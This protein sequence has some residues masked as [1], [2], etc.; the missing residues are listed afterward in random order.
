[1]LGRLA[2]S[3]TVFFLVQRCFGTALLRYSVASSSSCTY[4]CNRFDTAIQC[5]FR[6]SFQCS[7]SVLLSVL[8]DGTTL[9]FSSMGR[10]DTAFRCFSSM[11]CFDTAFRCSLSRQSLLVHLQQY[12]APGD[13]FL[14]NNSFA[15][16]SSGILALNTFKRVT[17]S[18]DRFALDCE[19]IKLVSYPMYPCNPATA[20]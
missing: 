7:A 20:G 18:L 3:G 17:K 19:L 10:F 2:A 11:G 15:S 1:M 5:S 8:F 4:S 16:I 13:Q 6:C 9:C 14:H 12:V